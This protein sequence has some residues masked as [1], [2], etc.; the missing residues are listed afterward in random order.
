MKFKKEQRAKATSDK[1]VGGQRPKS[2]GSS[3]SG[4]D[5]ENSSSC[6][7]PIGALGPDRSPTGPMDCAV[8]NKGDGLGP[9]PYHHQPHQP[10]HHQQKHLVTTSPRPTPASKAAVEVT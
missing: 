4:S 9:D 8:S 7:G 2:E 1:L 3:Y 5:T 6:H 10:Q